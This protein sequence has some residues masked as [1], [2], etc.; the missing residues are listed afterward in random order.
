MNTALIFRLAR[1]YASR[2]LFQSVL[3][4]LGVALGVGMIIAIDLANTSATR[5]FRLSTESVTGRATHQILGS[6]AGLPTDVFRQ[7]RV[8]LDVRTSAPVV[9]GYA[10]ALTFNGLPMRVLGVDPLL[11][12]PFRDYLTDT[13]VDDETADPND[14]L[15]AFI[16]RP[17]SAL[18]STNLASRF[19]LSVGDTI[20]LQPGVER[21]D[22]TVVGLLLPNDDVSTQALDDLLLVDIATAQATVG[23]PGRLSRVDLILPDEAT[24]TQVAAALP[25]GVRLSTVMESDSTIAQMTEAFDIN[26]Q[27]LSLLALVVGAF[28]IYN[29]VTFNVVQRRPVIGTL[30]SLGMTR[31]QV[32]TL[33]L[34]EALL[35]TLVGVVIGLALGIILGRGAVAVVSQAVNNLYLTVNVNTV[36]VNAWSLAK[37]A[38]IGFAVSTAAAVIPSWDATRTPPVGV[39]R[40]SSV[41]DQTV[42][43]LPAITG[44]AVALNVIGVGL[45]LLPTTSIW[46][47]FVALF[48]I[49]VGSASFTPLLLVVAMRL[50]TPLTAR[51]FGVLGRMAPRAVSRSLSRTSVAVAALTVAVSVIVGVSVMISSFRNTVGDWLDTTLGA[52]IY[53]SPPLLT[54][55][56]ATVGMEPEIRDLVAGVGGVT[57]VSAARSATAPSPD[58]PDMPPVNLTATDFDISGGARRFVWNN[59]PNDDYVAALADGLMMV[60]EPFAFRRGITPQNNTLTLQT[61]QGPQTFEIFGV[62]YDYSTDQGTVFLSMGTYHAYWNDRQLSSLAAYVDDPNAIPTI[63]DQ[64]ET[65][66]LAGLDV[67]VQSNRA[68]RQGVFEVFDQA[69]SITVALRLL[70]T[71]VAFIGILSAL[72]ALQMENTR[73][74]G[75]MRAIGLTP[76]QLREFTLIQTGLM[77]FMSGLLAIP[78]G[79]A[80]AAVLIFVINIRS[81]GW[82]MAFLPL[83]D[84]LIQAFVVALG[85]ALIAG[86]YPAW[87]LGNLLTAQALRA[88]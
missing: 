35:L 75:L 16:A 66:T 34:S 48:C 69:F 84:Q 32:F 73:Q 38:V 23:E 37:G 24:A 22:L 25:A 82:S 39:L 85:A 52:D 59:A 31:D 14:A 60:S 29:T 76:G 65:T 81:F 12:A 5:A 55:N 78:I 9:E 45:L 71:V 4:V 88:E 28:L 36:T 61:D 44:A 51:L 17:G 50:V 30:R 87:K 72:L 68:L 74:Y 11:E 56:R 26:L 15:N 64:L 8:D 49:V 54:A 86:V 80:L 77:G 19:D 62:F 21:V 70:A 3:F 40:R 63:I 10:R 58:F 79:L 13:T 46:I 57:Q 53:I 18:I 67:Q 42:K 41:E 43:R 7:V 6:G 1:R 2:R 83:P 20:T 27:A 47:S 33:V